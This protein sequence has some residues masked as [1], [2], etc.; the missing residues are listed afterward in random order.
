MGLGVELRKGS[1]PAFIGDVGMF[2]ARGG[3]GGLCHGP[4]PFYFQVCI[5]RIE[6]RGGVNIDESM[7]LDPHD[8]PEWKD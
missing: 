1:G 7:N 8:E 4:I 3:H 5:L 2:F 6:C